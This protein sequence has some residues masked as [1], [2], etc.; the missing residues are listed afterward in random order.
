MRL[1]N[2]S[3]KSGLTW[4]IVRLEDECSGGSVQ[5]V[6]S[7]ENELVYRNAHVTH[8]ASHVIGRAVDDIVA[9]QS[10]TLPEGAV[11]SIGRI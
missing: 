6:A 8:S 2:S 3:A 5:L 1:K 9:V 11:V 4:R 10:L 7:V